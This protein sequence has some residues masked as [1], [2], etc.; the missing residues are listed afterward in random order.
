MPPD[1]AGSPTLAELRSR[2]EAALRD[3]YDALRRSQQL[4][5]RAEVLE[6]QAVAI[7]NAWSVAHGRGD[8]RRPH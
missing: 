3:S 5:A 2:A 4:L 6:R 8:P 1:Q 7:L